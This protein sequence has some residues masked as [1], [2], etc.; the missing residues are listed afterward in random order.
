MDTV[1]WINGNTLI[2]NGTQLKISRT[3]DVKWKTIG[4]Q[5]NSPNDKQIT[6]NKCISVKNNG[7][8]DIAWYSIGNTRYHWYWMMSDN[9]NWMQAHWEWKET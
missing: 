4:D 7:N 8:R 2:L 9:A 1:I 6:G 3:I 5:R